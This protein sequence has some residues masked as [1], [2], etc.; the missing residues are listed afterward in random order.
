M[1]WILKLLISGAGAPGD[2]SAG[3][4]LSGRDNQSAIWNLPSL[5]DTSQGSTINRLPAGPLSLLKDPSSPPSEMLDSC[6]MGLS[7]RQGVR[8]T[9]GAQFGLAKHLIT[10]PGLVPAKLH[11]CPSQLLF[12][13]CLGRASP[14]ITASPFYPGPFS[15]NQ[16]GGPPSEPPITPGPCWA[17]PFPGS[18]GD[19]TP[20]I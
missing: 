12:T 5:T 20:E 2:S 7:R 14:I 16:G 19:A 8:G 18:Q 4:D 1:V 17:P 15:P 3:A 11:G 13:W 9:A 10:R 6:K